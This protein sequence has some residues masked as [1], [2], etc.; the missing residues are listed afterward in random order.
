MTLLERID[1][2]LKEAMK[3]KNETALSTLRLVR[4]ALKNKQIDAQK[5]LSEADVTAVIKT[6]VKQYRDA[7]ADFSASG[8]QDLADRQA[9]EIA[10]LETYLPAGMSE[11]ELEAI[12]T[13]VISEQNAT[14][15]DLGRIMGLIM[16]EVN[17]GADGNTVRA[18]VQR[19]MGS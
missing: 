13:R 8:R 7:L 19:L 18:I 3:A 2:D 12:C 11:A 9:A 15:K 10:L 5:E 6:M 17:G 14:S 4:S 1:H 16:K